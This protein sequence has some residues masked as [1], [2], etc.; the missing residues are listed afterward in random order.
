MCSFKKLSKD[1]KMQRYFDGEGVT[2]MLILI[3]TASKT[4]MIKGKTNDLEDEKKKEPTV[5]AYFNFDF[6]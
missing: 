5:K 2:E 3:T 6:F 4:W 1:N